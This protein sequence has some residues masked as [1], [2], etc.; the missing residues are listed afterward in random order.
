MKFLILLWSSLLFYQCAEQP[1]QVDLKLEKGFHQDLTIEMTMSAGEDSMFIQ[2]AI[3]VQLDFVGPNKFKWLYQL[4][5]FYSFSLFNGSSHVV[6]SKISIPSPFSSLF[7]N[8]IQVETDEKGKPLN[9]YSFV[10]GKEVPTT[11]SVLNLDLMCIL[12]PE[13]KIALGSRWSYS[14]HNPFKGGSRSVS[15]RVV[16]IDDQEIKLELTAKVAGPFRKIHQTGKGFCRLDRKSLRL[17]NLEITVP[18]SNQTTRYKIYEQAS[19]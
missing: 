14:T 1:Q 12:F 3:D 4:E 15:C 11:A 5:E 16:K 10:N 6:D 19:Q 13:E 18:S 7:E 17:K 2:T 9:K 8:K